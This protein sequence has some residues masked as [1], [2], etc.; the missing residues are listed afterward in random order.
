MGCAHS[1]LLT[2]A[3]AWKVDAVSGSQMEVPYMDGDLNVIQILPIRHLLQKQPEWIMEKQKKFSNI[4][5][6]YFMAGIQDSNNM[7]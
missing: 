4:G 5:M 6:T 1:L 7:N 3:A 2:V